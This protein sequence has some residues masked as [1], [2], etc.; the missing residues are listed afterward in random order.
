RGGVF[1]SVNTRKVTAEGSA[2]LR[3]TV[4]KNVAATLL[5]DPVHRR[6]AE[7]CA[8][9]TFG[10]KEWFEDAGLGFTVHAK[11]GVADSEHDVVACFDR[12]MRAG[13]VFVQADVRSLDHQLAAFWHSIARIHGEVHDDLID[14]AGVGP[15]GA[16]RRSRHHNQI[17]VLADHAGEHF[18]VLS[19][20][21]VEVQYLGREHLLSAKGQ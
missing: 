15:H 17:D 6:K 9:G 20:N 13:E 18:Q 5:Y 14:L 21:V 7:P 10:G 1:P 19:D 2:A 11:P 12:S 3:L 4:D 16:D 8:L